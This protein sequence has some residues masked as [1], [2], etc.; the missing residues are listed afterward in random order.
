M[1]K[2]NDNNKNLYL[3]VSFLKKRIIIEN[4]NKSGVYRWTNL[5]NGKSYI[6]SSVDLLRRFYQYFNLKYLSDS[7]NKMLIYRAL[8][9][10]KHDNFSLEILEY[11][12]PDKCIEREQY[13]LD[14]YKHEYNT[15][16]IAGSLYGYKHT[17]E[18]KLKMSLAQKGKIFTE[19]TRLKLSL[20]LKGKIISAETRLKMSLAQKNRIVSAETKLKVSE[21][22]SLKSFKEKENILIKKQRSRFNLNENQI[23]TLVVK[24]I[25]TGKEN[26]FF[27]YKSA[28]KF[29][30]IDSK[31]IKKW[32]NTQKIYKNK[33][34]FNLKIDNY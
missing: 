1:L 15:L 7:K 2:N 33:Y 14:N 5:L 31:T 22:Y 26:I 16:T 32:A 23:W 10:Y 8:L 21:N 3:N 4:K 17:E 11:C 18:A 25:I 29:Y 30:K 20:A 9:E 12:E 34:T 28:A 13:Y 19:E 6:G 24:E 27:S